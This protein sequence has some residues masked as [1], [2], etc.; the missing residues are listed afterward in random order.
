M[1]K[2]FRPFCGNFQK[3]RPGASA[4]RHILFLLGWQTHEG[5]SLEQARASAYGN[6]L[7]SRDGRYSF[8]VRSEF[9]LSVQIALD[10]VLVAR[11]GGNQQKVLNELSLDGISP[12][13]IA[14]KHARP[15][16]ANFMLCC[17]L[18]CPCWRSLS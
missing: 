3:A 15:I 16:G 4:L 1:F 9:L 7:S 11:Q 2:V 6:L 14:A 12:L 5:G 13:Q 17:M 8:L 10:C 18:H